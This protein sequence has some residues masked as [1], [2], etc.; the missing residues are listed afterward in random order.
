MQLEINNRKA[1]FD[2]EVSQK[3]VKQLQVALCRFSGTVSRVRVTFADINGPRG[4]VDKR[5][6]ISAKMKTVGQVVVQG[7]GHDYTE[8]LLISLDKLTRAIRRD[9]EKG[10][11]NP[12][13]KNRILQRVS[14]GNLR[15]K[16]Y[17]SHTEN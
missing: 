5:C 14:V 15:S 9:L 13:R 2:D 4:G 8:A 6:R 3:V 10:R 12:I 16:R 1:G 11:T 7:D 17:E